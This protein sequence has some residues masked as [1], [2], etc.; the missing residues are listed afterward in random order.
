MKRYVLKYGMPAQDSHAGWEKNALPI[1]N[2]ALGMKV[3]GLTTTERLQF[4]EKSLWKGGPAK[5]RPDYMGGNLDRYDSLK[6]I[7]EALENNDEKTA[8]KLRQQLVGI[9]DGYGGFMPFGNVYIE[10]NHNN[11]ENYERGLCL[12]DSIS[13]VSYDNNNIHYERKH[14]ASIEDNCIVSVLSSSSPA[15]FLIKVK[16]DLKG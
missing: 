12:N 8:K 9:K 1:G 15:S 11:V 10:L 14:F 5:S 13:Y 3:F 7:Q 16:S 2:G 6:K 4:N